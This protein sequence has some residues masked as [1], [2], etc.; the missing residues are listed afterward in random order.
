MIFMLKRH[1]LLGKKNAKKTELEKTSTM[2]KNQLEISLK[3]S[4]RKSQNDFIDLADLKPDFQLK[5]TQEVKTMMS[6]FK[7]VVQEYVLLHNDYVR[8]KINEEK[9]KAKKPKI[10]EEKLD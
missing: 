1:N 6:H 9:A 10:N 8:M 3:T 2:I 7:Q 4:N 5:L